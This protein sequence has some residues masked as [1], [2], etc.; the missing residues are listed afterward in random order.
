MRRVFFYR[1][2]TQVSSNPNANSVSFSNQGKPGCVRNFKGIKGDRLARNF[3]ANMPP[4]L[5]RATL[6]ATLF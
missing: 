5:E 1:T 2:V 6:R 4:D 3:R